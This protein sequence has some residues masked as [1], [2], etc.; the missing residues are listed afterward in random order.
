MS[1]QNASNK[2]THEIF[3]VEPGKNPEDKSFWHKIGAGWQNAKGVITVKR[4][5]TPV[6]GME[7]VILPV[8]YKK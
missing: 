4:F 5:A 3:V 2:P 1:T 7:E 8:G 6:P